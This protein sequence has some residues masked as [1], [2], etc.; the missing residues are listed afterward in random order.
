MSSW[1]ISCVESMPTK[2]MLSAFDGALRLSAAAARN[3]GTLGLRSM[4]ERAV[5]LGGQLTVTSA[6]GRG[7]TIRIEAPN[8]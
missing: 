3:Q 8:E 6:P 7:T 1:N 4:Q 2:A 5:N